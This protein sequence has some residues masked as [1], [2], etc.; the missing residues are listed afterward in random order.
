MS[1]L[2]S[3]TGVEDNDL[4]DI[5]PEIEAMCASAGLEADAVK[6]IMKACEQ[7]YKEL[8][9]M[10]WFLGH[11]SDETATPWIALCLIERLVDKEAAK[12]ARTQCE[13]GAY[14]S[15]THCDALADIAFFITWTEAKLSDHMWRK[16]AMPPALK[17]RMRA[18]AEAAVASFLTIVPAVAVNGETLMPQPLSQTLEERLRRVDPWLEDVLRQCLPEMEQA[19][20]EQTEREREQAEREP[21]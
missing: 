12:C 5:V 16:V 13:S 21:P 20:R 4:K 14:A 19:M 1:K 6:A 3:E 8:H 7:L 2:E 9:W 17:A 18:A 15:M 10:P 11:A